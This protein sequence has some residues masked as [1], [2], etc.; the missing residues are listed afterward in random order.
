MRAGIPLI[1]GLALAACGEERPAQ[2]TPFE[3]HPPGLWYDTRFAQRAPLLS[4]EE[5]R[6]MEALGTLGYT[7]GIHQA[8]EEFGVLVWD[9]ERAAP[10]WNL[11]CSGHAAEAILMDMAGETVHRWALAFDDLPDAPT[12]Y[13]RWKGAWRRLHLYPDGSLLA[14]YSHLGLVKVDRDSRRLWHRL[15]GSHHDLEVQP[16]GHILVLTQRERHD[17]RL[18]REGPIVEDLVTELDA[19]GNE[20]RS[21]SL[22]RAM[23]DSD[24]ADLLQASARERA[25]VLHANTIE[26]LRESPRVPH[27]AFRPGRVLVCFREL[28]AVAVV[29]LDR[30]RVVW[31][32]Q[33]P[34][35]MPHQPT[36]L[37]DGRLMVFDNM[38]H[39][40]FSRVV[41]FDVPRG[42][43]VWQY[44]GDPPES[45]FSIFSGSAQRLPGGT[46]L[47]TESYAGRALEVTREGRVVW[48][49]VSPHR[50]GERG[51]LVAVLSEVLRLP[52]DTP[53]GWLEGAERG[54]GAEDS[55]SPR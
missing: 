21:V 15:D 48:E 52:P 51:E 29:D 6:A 35:G 20:L 34:W 26:V 55:D 18:R 28:H 8:P 54:H 44:A 50:A 2:P 30:E 38:G 1:V 46:T 25:D 5:R 49:F 22:V 31:L 47:V 37:E 24:W 7:E 53:L 3:D 12:Q 45:L 42:E 16:G 43:V 32:Q 17:P 40:G 14:I 10:G 11:Y 9:R 23:Q 13:E 19:D 33:G 36:V 41:E 39:Q 4:E 27:P